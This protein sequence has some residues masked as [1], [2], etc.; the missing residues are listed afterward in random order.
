MKKFN[1]YSE[2]KIILSDE[3]EELFESS[4]PK[5]YENIKDLKV[6]ESYNYTEIHSGRGWEVER[7]V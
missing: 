2:G 3:P 4:T 7:I 1:V 6:G 5:I